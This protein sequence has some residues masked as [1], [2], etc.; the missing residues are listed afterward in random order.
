MPV[1]YPILGNI[2]VQFMESSIQSVLFQDYRRQLETWLSISEYTDDEAY[3]REQLR[4]NWVKAV[5]LVPST[6]FATIAQGKPATITVLYNEIDPLWRGVVPQFVSGLATQLNREIFLRSA[7]EQ[8][9]VLADLSDDLTMMLSGR[10]SR[11]R[12]NMLPAVPP[13]SYHWINLP[14][15]DSH[16]TAACLLY[17]A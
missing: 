8:R 10:H 7:D 15:L 3:A 9:T 4:L 5:L 14:D 1:V 2:R 17:P 6:P 11:E 12:V 13:V 16:L